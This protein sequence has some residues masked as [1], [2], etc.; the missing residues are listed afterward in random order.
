MTKVYQVYCNGFQKHFLTIAETQA[1]IN[2]LR[3]MGCVGKEVVISMGRGDL[4]AVVF[5]R[6]YPERREVLRA[7]A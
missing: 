2:E 3:G 4:K 1:Y 7:A 5:D 6:G